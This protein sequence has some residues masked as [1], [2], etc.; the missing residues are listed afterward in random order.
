MTKPPDATDA[1]ADLAVGEQGGRFVRRA[2]DA[3]EDAGLPVTS[4]HV[5]RHAAVAFLID[6][7]LNVKE[8]STY[9]GRASVATTLDGYGHLLRGSEAAAADRLDSYCEGS[10]TTLSPPVR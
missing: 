4:L 9:I 8:I 3:W 6:V 10:V 5:G 2:K 1:A 7:G